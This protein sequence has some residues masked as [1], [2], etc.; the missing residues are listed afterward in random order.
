MVKIKVKKEKKKDSKTQ[1]PVKTENMVTL[2]PVRMSDDPTPK[3]VKWIN[4]QRVL[5]FAARGINHRHRHLMEDIKKLMPHHKTESKMERSK[6]LYVVNEI[7]EMKNCNKCILFEGRK[8][9]DLYLWMSNIPNG[10]SVKFLVENIYTMGELKMTGNCLR[11]SR[12]LLSFDPQFAKDAHYALL[13]ELLIQIFGVPKHH[14]KS[15]PFF[16]HV[17]TFMILD[18]RIWFRNYQILSEDGALAEIGP[19]FVLN[20]VKIFSGSFGG[21]TLWENSKYISPAKL[22]QAFSK[23][24]ANKYEKRIEKK[25]LNEA[26]KPVTGYPDIEDASFFKGDPVKKAENVVIKDE[27]KDEPMDEEEN[28]SP[29]T[30]TVKSIKKS[31]TKPDMAIRRKQLKA[32][33]KKISDQIKKR[34]QFKKKKPLK[35]K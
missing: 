14:P 19:R 2:P 31:K 27:I 16:D 13:K 30:S 24:A 8:M 26:S 1:V 20:P 11:G 35:S 5:V 12:P 29:D 6:N 32:K 7:S 17:Y 3:Q 21:S 33:S 28:K 9:R 10:P 23:R 18:N 34:K 25:V 22:R 15:Q 4:R